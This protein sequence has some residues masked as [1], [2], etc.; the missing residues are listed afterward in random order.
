MKKKIFAVCDLE[1]AYAYNLMEYIYDRQGTDFEIQA[2]TSVRTL[3]V[4]AREQPID[5]LLISSQAMC[6]EIR[7]LGIGRVMILSEGELL[8]ELSEYPSVYKYQASDSLIAEVMSYYAA[9]NTS[10]P[11]AKLKKKVKVVGIYSPI[12]RTL[13]TSFALTLG[14]ILAK[15]QAV[16]YLNLE[17]YAG[18][19][20]LMGKKFKAD[21]SD[22]MYFIRQGQGNLLYHL[23]SIV[24]NLNNLDYVPPV[25][26]PGDLRSVSFEEWMK[27]MEELLTYSSYEVILLDMDEQAGCLTELLKLCDRIYMPVREDSISLAKLEQF[28]AI[29]RLQ[30][31]EGI[32]EK[33]RK[34]K[35]PFHS[36]FG[37]KENYVSWL[38][39]GELGDYVRSLIREEES[40]EGKREPDAAA[41]K[42]AAGTVG[43]VAGYHR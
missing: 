21:I 30:G 43:S 37:P 8:E 29:M 41:E 36:S 1:A 24:Q 26:L 34:L 6:Q 28:E 9:G 14:Q 18:F 20:G 13:K 23:E 3:A 5:L 32:L 15:D 10:E 7:E 42:P 22:L 11:V 12:R 2:F 25:F 35:L 16:L 33:T 39:W 31:A 17:D 19:E 27:L 38:V 4:Y 40:S